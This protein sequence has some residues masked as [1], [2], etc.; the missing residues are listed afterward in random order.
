MKNGVDHRISK[1]VCY[2][3]C[4]RVSSDERDLKKAHPVGPVGWTLEREPDYAKASN[5]RRGTGNK[6]HGRAIRDNLDSCHV[7]V[8]LIASRL[9]IEDGPNQRNKDHYSS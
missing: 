1:R 3:M 2:D 4:S 9:I 6:W 8:D 7:R 5:L